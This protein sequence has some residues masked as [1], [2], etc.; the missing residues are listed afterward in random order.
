MWSALLLVG[1]PLALLLGE[2]IDE[3][4]VLGVVGVVALPVL[5]GGDEGGQVGVLAPGIAV[6]GVAGPEADRGY[7]G[8][9]ELQGRGVVF[10]E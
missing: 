9:G 2:P 7:G 6:D 1:P 4:L 10:V 8:P 3:L 5:L